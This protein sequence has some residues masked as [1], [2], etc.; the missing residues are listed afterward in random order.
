MNKT[1]CSNFYELNETEIQS[2]AGA[3]TAEWGV[4][5]GASVA[6][7]G[8]ALAVTTPIGIGVLAGASIVSSSMAMWY[9]IK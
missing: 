5:V 2:V 7:L 4:S 6:F 8:M 3:G 9:A 1:N